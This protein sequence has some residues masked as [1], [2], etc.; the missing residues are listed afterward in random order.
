MAGLL[1]TKK[2]ARPADI[3][4]IGCQREPGTKRVQCLHDLEAPPRLR[5]QQTVWIG[6]QIGIG[7]LAAAPDPAAKLIQLRQP[8]HVGSMDDHRVGRRNVDSR[9]NDIGRQQDV[10]LAVS[11]FRHHVVE[12]GGGHPAVRR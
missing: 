9:F 10:G 4:V 11:K 12:L 2:I 7:P 5:G 8:E 6:R 3:H 1:I